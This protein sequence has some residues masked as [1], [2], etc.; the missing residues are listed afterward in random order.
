MADDDLDQPVEGDDPS[1]QAPVTPE[2]PD[3]E[4]IVRAVIEKTVPEALNSRISGL[5]SSMDK[6]FST[7]AKELKNAGLSEDDQQQILAEEQNKETQRAVQLAELI[8]R[9]KQFPEAVEFMIDN[10][11]RSDLDDQLSF[12]QQTLK[13]S[14]A[15]S[16]APAAPSSGS[17]PN[18]APVPDV[19][20]NNP[21]SSRSPVLESGE[22]MNEELADAILSQVS[23]RGQLSRLLGRR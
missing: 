2:A 16:P 15:A 5:Q 17:A 14:Q 3:L 18:D 13:P 21:A 9:R 12:I 23:G 6:R 7:L 11:D 10:M 22:E 8:K 4:A 20:K 1:A 19:D